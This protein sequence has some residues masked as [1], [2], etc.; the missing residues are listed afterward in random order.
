ML[1]KKHLN[2]ILKVKMQGLAAKTK[3]GKENG[4]MNR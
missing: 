4:R 2:D 3:R 1:R